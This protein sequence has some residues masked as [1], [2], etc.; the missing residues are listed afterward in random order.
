MLGPV[1]HIAT[2]M[3]GGSA[4][5]VPPGLTPGLSCDKESILVILHRQ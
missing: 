2:N 5:K 4:P 3:K 1:Q